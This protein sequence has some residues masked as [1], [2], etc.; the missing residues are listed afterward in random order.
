MRALSRASFAL[1]A[2]LA[3]CASQTDDPLALPAAHAERARELKLLTQPP[4]RVQSREDFTA[5]AQKSASEETDDSI[6]RQHDTYGRLGFYPQTFDLRAGDG[7]S[8]DFYTAYYSSKTKSVTVVDSPEHSILVHELTHALQDQYF[9]L[10]SIHGEHISSDEELAR[11]GLIEGDARMAEFRDLILDRGQDPIEVLEPF[12]TVG[13]AYEEA[14]KLFRTSKVPL[15]FAA[16]AAF[17]YTFGAAFVGDGLL[18]PA[19]RWDYSRVNALFKAANGPLSTKEV[20]LAGAPVGPIV[21]AGLSDLPPAIASDWVVETVDR[22]GEWYTYVLLFPGARDPATLATL[23]A[24]WNG[25]Q[26]VVLRKKDGSS[27][28]STSSPSGL[29]WTS[30]WDDANQASAFAA[31]LAR[32]HAATPKKDDGEPAMTSGKD[33]EAIW[34]EQRER[35]VCFVKNLAPALAGPLAHAALYTA[36]ERRLEVLRGAR[37]K[38]AVIH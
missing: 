18:L 6:Q 4:L 36:K 28:P 32:V 33:G 8:S 38:Q 19:G 30:V 17:A 21:D 20:I 3:A 1:L 14:G 27:P 9:D 35:H 24:G 12:V 5:D 23:T 10:K 22:M 16:H 13:R 29:V 11:G 26:L 37:S 34:L 2:L 7:A 25:D 15:I 31:E